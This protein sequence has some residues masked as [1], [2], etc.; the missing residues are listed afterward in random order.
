MSPCLGPYY[1]SVRSLV[2]GICT[3]PAVDLLQAAPGSPRLGCLPPSDASAAASQNLLV[4]VKS[5]CVLRTLDQIHTPPG[6]P[7]KHTQPT[8]LLTLPHLLTLRF[9][10]HFQD[11]T[12]VTVHTSESDEDASMTV[13]S[14]S[15]SSG[16]AG[17]PYSSQGQ[18][19]L[20]HLLVNSGMAWLWPGSGPLCCGL[21]SI[22]LQ[23]PA[24]QRI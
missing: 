11:G 12:Q 8:C 10:S 22:G 3:P 19:G 7:P 4:S 9:S 23:G 20:P 14:H 18:L 15:A 21:W 24:S 1:T 6:P 5:L 17:P 16:L 13:K 2:I